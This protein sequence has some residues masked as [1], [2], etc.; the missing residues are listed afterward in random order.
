[1]PLPPAPGTYVLILEALRSRSIRV[2]RLGTLAVSPGFYLY[3]GSA[4]GPGGLKARVERHLRSDKRHHWH[5]DHLRR[6]AE[7]VEVWWGRDP[8]PREHEWAGIL[9][10]QPGL[11]VQMPGFG[12]SDCHCPTH[13]FF[14]RE[15]VSDPSFRALGRPTVSRAPFG[16]RNALPERS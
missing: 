9:V 12:A 5:I 11:E 6:V 10:A 1:M 14:A 2:G 7:I 16:A 3:V 13:L 15:R 8:Q 4:F